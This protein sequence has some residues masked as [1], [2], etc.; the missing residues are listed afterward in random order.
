[1][2]TPFEPESVV[3]AAY[4]DGLARGILDEIDYADSERLVRHLNTT[5]LEFVE[6]MKEKQGKGTT[7]G[8]YDWLVDIRDKLLERGVL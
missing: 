1:M 8:Q 4:R 2:P 7:K 5:E 3:A 6:Q